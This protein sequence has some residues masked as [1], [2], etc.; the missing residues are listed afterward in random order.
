MTTTP[1]FV[2]QGAWLPAAGE[3]VLIGAPLA[4]KLGVKVGQLVALSAVDRYSV[5]NY[6]EVPVT[7]I[8]SLGL[9]SMDENLIFVDLATAQELLGIPGAATRIVVKL[10]EGVSESSALA[11]VRGLLSGTDESAYPWQRFAQVIVSATSADVGGFWIV[12]CVIFLLVVVGIVN[13]MSMTIRERTREIGTLRAIGIRRPQLSLLFIVEAGFIALA[14]AA[15]GC[16]LGGTFAWYMTKVGIDL[17]AASM[18]MP[19]PFGHRFTG[20]YRLIDFVLASVVSLA[21]A[22]AGSVLPTRR[23]ARLGIP[24]ALGARVD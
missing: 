19:I 18:E 24:Q 14:A 16:I 2:Q 1:G 12:F 6:V 5:E 23:A 17:S 10:N 3:G 15:V 11:S 7:G 13:S 9:P 22:L 8:F 21:S 20:D 4:R